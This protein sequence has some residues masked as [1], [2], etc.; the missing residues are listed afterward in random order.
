MENKLQLLIEKIKK[1]EKEL[2]DEIRNQEE[3]FFYKIRGGKVLF[4]KNVKKK[5]KAIVKTVSRYLS[6]AELL[7]ILTAPIIWFCIFPALFMD[8][9]VTF[10]QAICFR[11]YGIPRVKRNKYIVIDRHSLSYL[12]GIEKL[13]CAYCGY[14][15][16]LIVYVQEV[17]ARTEQY[18]CPIKH[19]RRT[20]LIH[21]RYGKFFEY[22]DGDGYRNKVEEV[23]RDFDDIREGNSENS[24]VNS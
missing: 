23:R 8:L 4:E 1:L 17:A 6:D 5:H 3:M 9:V 7:N 11:I 14:F 15:N 19:A 12:N 13:N 10:Y 2:A 16:G 22:G 24:S 21:S 18:W 20:A